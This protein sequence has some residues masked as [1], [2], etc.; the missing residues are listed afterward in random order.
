MRRNGLA[1]L[2]IALFALVSFCSIASAVAQ[3]ALEYEDGTPVFGSSDDGESR[4]VVL[5]DSPMPTDLPLELLPLEVRS[6]RLNF[7]YSI[8]SDG[9]PTGKTVLIVGSRHLQP[10]PWRRFKGCNVALRGG[11]IIPLY[12]ELYF[13]PTIGGALNLQRVSDMFP[14]EMLPLPD[15]LIVM[16][17]SVVTRL[18][19]NEEFQFD[20]LIR[21]DSFL[22]PNTAE[23]EPVA[24]VRVNPPA[25]RADLILPDGRALGRYMR[26]WYSLTVRTGDYIATEFQAY[27]VR[28]VVPPQGETKMP[29][30]RR[31]R[32]V[33]WVEIDPEPLP[34]PEEPAVAP[35]EE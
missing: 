24:I 25:V 32:V 18:F 13:V 28:N 34:P 15:S 20:G 19:W 9:T 22:T 14:E 5:I 35:E 27:R 2:G 31:G 7:T 16:P 8:R 11:D 3:P 12:G 6:R 30:G 4:G 33:G 23:L 10:G 29:D 26:P 1:F 17:K 21:L